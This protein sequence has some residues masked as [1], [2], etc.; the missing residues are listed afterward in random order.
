MNRSRVENPAT[1]K[2]S[3]NIRQ[4]RLH[5]ERGEAGKMDGW[6]GD[7]IFVRR[8]P[9]VV[10]RACFLVENRMRKR[11]DGRKEKGL[12]IPPPPMSNP[13]RVPPKKGPGPPCSAMALGEPTRAN[14]SYL[15]RVKSF[16]CSRYAQVLFME[17]DPHADGV[18]GCF[19]DDDLGV[20]LTHRGQGGFNR[21][22]TRPLQAMSEVGPGVLRSVG[23][24]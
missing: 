11:V 13:R 17:T 8:R 10:K 19:E 3:K 2:R 1:L 9:R 21:H 4:M 24:Q 14:N 18:A 7:S 20:A 23:L 15:R 22:L 12:A 16:C 6:T 5:G